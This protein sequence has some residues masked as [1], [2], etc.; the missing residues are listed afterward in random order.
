MT[1]LRFEKETS[2]SQA[3]DSKMDSQSC[4]TYV[5]IQ[6]FRIFWPYFSFKGTHIFLVGVTVAYF[7]LKVGS[8]CELLSIVELV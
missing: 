3:K 5:K 6:V 7:F 4:Q 1:L 2:T 8:Q